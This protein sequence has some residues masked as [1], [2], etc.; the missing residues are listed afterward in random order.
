MAPPDF[1]PAEEELV[2]R[3]PGVPAQVSRARGVVTAALGRD[4]PLLDEAVLLTS[5]LATNAVLHTQSGDGGSFTVAVRSRGSLVRVCVEDAGSDGPPCACRTGVYAT[6]GRGLPLLE[7]L[8]H[9]WG[10][11]RAN[12][13]NI[14]WFELLLVTVPAGWAAE[15]V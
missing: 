14:V 1:H 7:A 2:V 13:A 6:R 5:E 11:V 4:H 15:P 9:R 10:Y 12:G 8:S 3:L